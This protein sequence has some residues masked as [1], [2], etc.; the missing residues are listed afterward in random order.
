MTSSETSTATPSA[1]SDPRPVIVGV[2][3]SDSSRRALMWAAFVARSM[4]VGLEA[5]TAWQPM[6]NYT[7]GTAGWTAFPGD[8]DPAEDAQSVLNDTVAKA[9]GDS[10]PDDLTLSVRE[11]TA[12]Q[13]LIDASAHATMIVVGSRGHGGFAGLLL[14]SVSAACSEHAKSPVLVVH[15][16]AVP[17]S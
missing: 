2:D 6:G 15:G 17:A 16:D 8:W 5:V 3:G 9:F 13:V 10:R 1:A 14:G 7:L 4:G 12:A 11:G